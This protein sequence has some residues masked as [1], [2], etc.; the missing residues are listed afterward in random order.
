MEAVITIEN[1]M[2]T[3]GG[4]IVLAPSNR[5]LGPSSIGSNLLP[6]TQ[7]MLK[8]ISRWERYP[9]GDKQKYRVV[10]IPTPADFMYLHHAYGE[11]TY[12]TQGQAPVNIFINAG[13]NA[14]TYS[15]DVVANWELA[16]SSLATIATRHITTSSSAQTAQTTTEA[17]REEPSLLGKARNLASSLLSGVTPDSLMNAGMTGAKM[18]KTMHDVYQSG[19]PRMPDPVH[20]VLFPGMGN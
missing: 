13:S 17:I 5:T 6:S 11:T 1:P 18:L 20:R 4:D 8:P 7:A 15:M 2:L 3:A 10:W 16:G 9:I 12:L 19:A 14:I